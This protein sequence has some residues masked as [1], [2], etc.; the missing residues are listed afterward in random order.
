[1]LTPLLL[2][3]GAGALGWWRVRHSD[4]RT[5]PAA[6]QLQQAYHLNTLQATIH[7]RDIAQVLTLLRAAGLEPVLVKGWASAQLYPEPGLRPYGDLDLCVRLEQYVAAQAVLQSPAGRAYYV[8]L[9]REFATLDDRSLDDLYPHSQLVRLSEVDVRLLGPEDHLRLLCVH[10]LRHG[11]WR[12]LWLCDIAAALESRPSSFDWDRCL[13]HNRRRADWVACTIGL[14]HQLLGVSIEDTPGVWR[15]R[16]LPRWLVPSVL[17][18][19]ERPYDAD[20][21]PPVRFAL[22]LCHPARVPQALCLRWPPNPI[23]ATI[24]FNGPLNALPRWP[25]QIAEGAVRLIQF[26]LRRSA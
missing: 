21:R 16:H 23:A 11:A 19:W 6:L 25:F 26:C 7:E 12:P 5:S 9:H 4:L 2:G 8:D 13:G 22:T 15:A 1:M 3:S 10:F 17:Q 20:H 14:A 18:Q 24:G